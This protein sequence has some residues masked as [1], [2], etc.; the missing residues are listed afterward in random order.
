MGRPKVENPKNTQ[1]G[2]RF[3]Q[4]LL[5]KLDILADYYGKTRAETVRIGVET[6]YSQ[7]KK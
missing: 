3:D 4:E 7:L 2:I 1:L 5:E 6:L